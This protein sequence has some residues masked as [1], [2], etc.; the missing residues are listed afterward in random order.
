MTD[1]LIDFPDQTCAG[2]QE[3]HP[4]QPCALQDDLFGG[5]A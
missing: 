3:E 2:C 5:A 4:G 1:T